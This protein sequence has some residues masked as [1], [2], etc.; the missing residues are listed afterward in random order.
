M[1]EVN[2][3]FLKLVRA[4]SRDQ[5]VGKTSVELGLLTPEVRDRQLVAAVRAGQSRAVAL[6]V[7][8]FDGTPAIS[9]ISFTRYELEGKEYLLTS[10]IDI[11]DRLRAEEAAR[12]ELAERRSVQR[13]LDLAL[14][15]AGIG[16]WEFDPASGW[17]QADARL[18]E[19]YGVPLTPDH[20]MRIEQWS[21]RVHP[22]DRAHAQ[23]EFRRAA[24]TG[25]EVEV[26]LRARRPDGRELFL[27]AAATLLPGDGQRPD[28]VVGV[29]VD[30]TKLKTTELEL[31]LHQLD[32]EALVVTR[33]KELSAAKDAAEKANRAKGVFLAHMSHEIRT[34]MNAILG[35]AQLLRADNGLDVE[36]R[37]KIGAIHSSGDHLLG[38]LNDILEMSRIEAGRTTLSAEPFDLHA[39]IDGVHS[40]FTEVTRR[41][42]IAF[43]VELDDH[44]VRALQSDPGKVRQVLIN[45][46]GN[47]SK[48]TD[49]G[50]IAV[51][52][53]SRDASP[54]SS[55]V[56]IEVRDTGPGIPAD[57]LELIFAAFGQSQAGRS[58]PGTGLGLAISQSF[59]R[60]LGGDLTVASRMGEGSTFTFTFVANR[61]PES[62]LPEKT[63]ARPQRLDPSETRRRVLVVDDVP[64]NREILAEVLTRAGFEA[65]TAASGEEAVAQHEAW[66]PDL[67]MMDLHMPGMGGL[68]AIRHL[69]RA[70]TQA[71]IVVATAAADDTTSE[72]VEAAG[73]DAWI[74]KPY[75]DTDL[76]DAIAKSMGVSFIEAPAA[77]S[78]ETDPP[79]RPLADLLRS[80]PEDLVAEMRAA[81]KQ[82]RATRLTALAERVSQHSV[83][84]GAAIR[85]MA[86]SFRYKA[87]LEALGEPPS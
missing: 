33:T 35:Y 47:A 12:T 70:G 61:V 67:V 66:R 4:K 30:I 68:A 65:H 78:A 53:T 45:L 42:G 14:N 2:D 60:L 34:P 18:F 84:A 46:L 6:P 52:V 36:Q 28:R 49:K 72:D 86:N 54:D 48:F 9:E 62:E 51:R 83:Q 64:S 10:Q 50:G 29:T 3:A 17:I 71:A 22:D 82:A 69:R 32:L 41:K 85:E 63:S 31:R 40:M 38:L 59:A 1:L 27:H 5:V 7:R 20:R 39:L 15:A 77:N 79:E 44:L 11:T 8:T 23:A 16:T 43:D 74:R 76:F 87:I 73:A 56:T 21:E 55:L 81:A 24:E 25:A 57:D 19:L 75:R 13:R 80:L 37:R 58:R 26:D